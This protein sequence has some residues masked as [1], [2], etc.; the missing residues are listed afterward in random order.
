MSTVGR[1]ADQPRVILFV[2]DGLRP[3]RIDPQRTPTLWRVRQEGF[4][5]PYA[6]TVFP[7]ETRVA[8]ASLVTGALPGAHGIAANDFF[9]SAVFPDRPVATA[10]ADDLAA[11]TR[12]RGR[13]LARRTLAERAIA[14]GLRYAVV[15][16]ASAGT[17]RLIAE[18]ARGPDAFVWSRHPGIETPG[19]VAAGEAAFGPVPAAKLPR[20]N[21]IA[22]AARVFVRLALDSFRADLAV[23]WSGEPDYS[24]HY[25]AIGAPAASAAE[26]AADNALAAVLAWL[27]DSG[28]AG[29]TWLFV[30]SDHGHITGRQRI[31]V[32]ALLRGGGFDDEFLVVPGTA[33]LVYR[34]TSDARADVRLADW[35]AVQPWCDAVFN[36]AA[37]QDLGLAGHAPPS[38]V[39]SLRSDDAHDKHGV[40]GTGCFDCELQVGAGVHGGLHR[41]ELA[42][43]TMIHGPEGVPHGASDLPAGLTDIAPTVAAILRLSGNGFD[44]RVLREALGQPAS[45]PRETPQRELLQPFRARNGL[46]LARTRFDGRAYLDGLV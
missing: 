9:D 10:E 8:A 15:S 45:N 30:L 11:V 16:T 13:L 12:V 44:G 43:V 17:S 20:G 32:R 37:W 25:S 27:R 22:H 14:Q 34:R 33:S 39:F 38:L 19:A 23:F 36:A 40:P 29:R 3:D 31:D 42:N 35:L 21:E 6:R 1:R 26:A 41:R 24:Y 4:R 5:Y 28:D 46:R 18:G 7:S 2:C